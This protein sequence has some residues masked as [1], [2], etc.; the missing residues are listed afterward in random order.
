LETWARVS[1]TNEVKTQFV[2]SDRQ[3]LRP[4]TVAVAKLAVIPKRLVPETV[5]AVIDE[6]NKVVP[7]A[8][9]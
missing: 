1:F 8:A 6:P 5:E 7:V 9:P 4:A 2:P 3:R